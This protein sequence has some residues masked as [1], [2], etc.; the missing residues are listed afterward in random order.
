[1]DRHFKW[2]SRFGY[3]ITA[4]EKKGMD[5]L[6]S[7][8][9]CSRANKADQAYTTCSSPAGCETQK[10]SPTHGCKSHFKSIKH[11]ETMAWI[12]IMHIQHYDIC[13][14]QNNKITV[15]HKLWFK[16]NTLQRIVTVILHTYWDCT[17]SGLDSFSAVFSSFRGFEFAMPGRLHFF[18][19]LD[20][21]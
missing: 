20:F 13:L 21:V 6:F 15:Y 8:A 2:L 12:Y 10:I 18:T 9:Q 3:S 5:P 14:Y 16:W 7:T 17:D 1:M 4:A 19:N 11:T